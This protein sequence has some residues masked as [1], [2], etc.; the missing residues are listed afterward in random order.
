MAIHNRILNHIIVTLQ[1]IDATQGNGDCRV[2]NASKI[3]D[4]LWAHAAINARD[5][6]P[7]VCRPG[8][9]DGGEKEQKKKPKRHRGTKKKMMRGG[10]Q[11]RRCG[12]RDAG[13]KP[14]KM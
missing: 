10:R 9:T 4:I 3:I 6:D 7:A 8:Q 14:V 11:Q 5:I 12:V 13:K 1:I 2:T